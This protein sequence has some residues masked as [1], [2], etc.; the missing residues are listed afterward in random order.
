MRSR[1]TPAIAV[2]VLTTVAESRAAPSSCGGSGRPWVGITGSVPELPALAE[3]LRVELA[4]RGID[5]CVGSDMHDVAP[6]IAS[7]D[8]MSSG[9]G[10]QI[11]VE[12]R[13]SLTAKRVARDIDLDA[14]PADG[15]PLTLAVAAGELLRASWA[16]LALA[17]TPHPRAA[18]PAAVE[19]VLA[20]EL[21]P[22][23]RRRSSANLSTVGAIEHW[24]GGGTLY[25]GDLRVTAWP[26]ARLAVV[27]RV[28]LRGSST[29]SAP[30]G[31]VHATAWVAG[32]G[33]ALRVTPWERGSGID[34]IAR[35]DAEGVS[36]AAVPNPQARAAAEAGVA[37]I[38]G[39]GADGWVD[40]GRS[41]RLVIE[42][43]ATVPVRAVRALDAGRDVSSV[44]GIGIAAGVGVGVV[45]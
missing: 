16:E 27:L 29:A 15:R 33:G 31:E 43:L 21:A 45:L 25:G 30:D 8:V 3:L 35:F 39:T 34:A 38:A 11:V 7:V 19:E 18:V 44:S 6:A 41:L 14:V 32:A 1:L 26:L 42:G 20:R 22:P 12:V 9:Q 28:G 37:L 2:L 17:S 13:D 23:E 5:L 4:G 40:L 36:Y 24:S 10:A